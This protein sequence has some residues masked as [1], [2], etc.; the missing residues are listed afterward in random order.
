ML[1]VG[2]GWCQNGQMISLVM[3]SND[4]ISRVRHHE[5]LVRSIHHLSWLAG[6]PIPVLGLMLTLIEVASVVMTLTLVINHYNVVIDR[7]GILC[8]MMCS[9]IL[10]SA[11]L[12]TRYKSVYFGSVAVWPSGSSGHLETV[13][14]ILSIKWCRSNHTQI[15]SVELDKKL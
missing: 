13:S 6:Q 9:L 7:S 12:Q 8:S 5:V 4:V 14:N 1:I 3:V 10:F 2:Y 11:C 15:S